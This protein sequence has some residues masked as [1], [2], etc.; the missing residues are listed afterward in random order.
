MIRGEGRSD[1]KVKRGSTDAT[2][3]PFY[4]QTE[5]GSQADIIEGW[6]QQKFKRDLRRVS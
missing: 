4:P 2:G 5:N 3:V 1:Q 6:L